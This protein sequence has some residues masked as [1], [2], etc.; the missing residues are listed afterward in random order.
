[1]EKAFVPSR[2]EWHAAQALI[3]LLSAKIGLSA[4]AQKKEIPL[5]DAA[6]R[7]RVVKLARQMAA[8]MIAEPTPE[9][10]PPA[11]LPGDCDADA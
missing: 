4:D 2:L 11:T 1:M 10:E 3:G 7:R 6:A 9:T 8:E 5:Y